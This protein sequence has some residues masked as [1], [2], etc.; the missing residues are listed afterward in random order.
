MKSRI[1]FVFRWLVILPISWVKAFW[2]SFISKGAH[3]IGLREK[4]WIACDVGLPCFPS[5][6]PDCSA[7]S[8]FKAT[9]DLACEHKV[10]LRALALRPSRVPIPPPWNT[11]ILSFEK[12]STEIRVAQSSH[13]NSSNG[14]CD[15]TSPC[16]HGS[17]SNGF[18]AR[19]SIMLPN[20]LKNSHDDKF[21]ISPNVP[22]I[23]YDGKLCFVRVLL[24][25]YKEGV[26]EEGAVVCAPNMTDLLSWTSSSGSLGGFEISQMAM[27]SYFKQQSFG[28]WV[29]EIPEDPV[30]LKSHRWPIGFVTSGFVRGSKKSMAVA[31]CEAV[32]LARLRSEQWNHELKVKRRRKDIY[33]LVR[34]LRSTAYR[35]G[36]ATVILEQQLEDVDFL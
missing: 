12:E 4:R 22:Q 14:S 29:L 17:I 33:V 6:F 8:F 30:A 1:H 15:V 28:Q 20:L 13:E 31:V 27:L 24:H 23:N 36:L 32:L 3:A 18:V 5:D 7:Y 9:E 21:I 19:T 10:N 11:I 25:A 2:I 34:N 16:S 35:L 26:F